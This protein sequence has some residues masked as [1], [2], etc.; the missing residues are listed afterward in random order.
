MKLTPYKQLLTMTKEAID[1][2]LA[3]VRSKSQRLKAELEI[4]G[5]LY[6]KCATLEKEINELCSQQDLNYDKIIDKLDEL[7]LAERR[8]EQFQKIIVEL[9]PEMSPEQEASPSPN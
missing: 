4:R 8:K 1:K 5:L 6:E 9:F 2:T 3:P 7:S